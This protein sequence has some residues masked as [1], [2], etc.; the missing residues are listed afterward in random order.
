[1]KKLLIIFPN[2]IDIA[3]ISNSVPILSGIAKH[4]GWKVEY[5]DTYDY[6]KNKKIIQKE[7]G[8]GFKVSTTFKIKE[9]KKEFDQIPID[10]Q[11]IIDTFNPDIIAITALSSEY[12]FLMKFWNKIKV[13]KNTLVIIGGIHVTLVPEK[14]IETKLFDLVVLG[15]GEATFK[16]ILLRIE[17]NKE[18]HN[19]E[20]TYFYNRKTDK[21]TKNPK[22][23]LLPA[24]KL[25]E[26][27]NDYS[28][29]SDEFFERPYDGKKIRRNEIEISRGCPFNCS[30]CSNSS[31]KLFN[32]GLGKY[33]KTKPINSSI[34]QMKRLVDDFK[35][36]I[37]SLADECFLSHKTEWLKEFI[38]KY[39]ENVNKP[40][41]FMTRP[42][43]VTEEKI[44]LLIDAGIPFQASIGV[45]SGS[46]DILSNVCNRSCTPDHIRKAFK[47]LNKYKVR[48][49]AFFIVGFPFETREKVFK[50]INL[51]REIK[52]SVSS[53]SIFQPYPGQ[54]LTQDCINYKFFDGNEIPGTFTANSLL[55]MP[56]P[57]LSKDEIKNLWRVF[58]L[59]ASLPK[60]YY[61]Q[62]KRCEDD[63][64]NNIELYKKLIKLR[65]NKY[66]W[67]EKKGDIKLI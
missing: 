47:I 37:F 7:E 52:P 59:Y 38:K 16:D 24:E 36:D 5:F 57:Y 46:E 19:I 22:R 8:G 61:P 17:N 53:V 9:R 48:T 56:K 34:M 40:Y 60:K 2:A 29:F 6:K 26:I 23:Y 4:L 42:E 55:N 62:I 30:Y 45:E 58:M 65:W 18:I 35:V 21:I 54:K 25:W 39:K 13:S 50:S 63:Y 3:T 41:F 20:G 44:E 27:E 67:G 15:E 14:T 33:V 49:N 51:A 11:N 12:D 64:E 31:L 1:M 43:T 66:D 10:L 28:L 32:K